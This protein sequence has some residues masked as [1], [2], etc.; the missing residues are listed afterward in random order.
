MVTLTLLGAFVAQLPEMLAW[1]AGIA[2]A[3]FHW[4]R[5][6]RLAL[7]VLIAFILLL[8][9]RL[10]GGY[11]DT[12]LPTALSGVAGGNP[13]LALTLSACAQSV[14]AALA[15]VMI[16]IALFGRPEPEQGKVEHDDH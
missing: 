16:L 10:V 2:L 15:W 9:L 3:L 6:P 1:L 4:R 7:L 13:G 5:N 8:T 11:L 12:Q 14:A